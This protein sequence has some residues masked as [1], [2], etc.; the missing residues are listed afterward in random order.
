MNA[1]NPLYAPRNWSVQRA[2]EG[3]ERGDLAELRR[4]QTVFQRPY[5]AQAGAEDLAERRPEW[6]RDKPG[7]SALSCSS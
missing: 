4:L 1:L 5:E 7:C 2:I 6:A 3:A